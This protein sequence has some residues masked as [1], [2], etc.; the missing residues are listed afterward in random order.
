MRE[1]ERHPDRA[2]ADDG[3]TARTLTHATQDAGRGRIGSARTGETWLTVQR[4]RTALTYSRPTAPCVG[5]VFGL[6]FVSAV[7]R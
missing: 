7:H 5:T 1:E 3:L 6:A 4:A 2:E